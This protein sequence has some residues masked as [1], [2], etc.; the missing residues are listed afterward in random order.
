MPLP[1]GTDAER[2]AYRDGM[3]DQK[4]ASHDAH[5]S[6]INGSLERSASSLVEVEKAVARIGD[7]VQ[8]LV[9]TMPSLE[10]LAADTA[11]SAETAHQVAEALRA[12]TAADKTT[13]DRYRGIVAWGLG[14]LIASVTIANFTSRM[15]GI[16]AKQPPVTTVTIPDITPGY[17]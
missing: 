8:G 13:W 5:F 14:V 10:R 12:K 4:L 17:P 3:V 2:R 16:A 11:T 6:D 9:L 15:L 1:G 7:Q